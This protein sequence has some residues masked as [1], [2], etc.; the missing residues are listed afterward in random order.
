MAS[1]M[2]SDHMMLECGHG[3]DIIAS[4]C[5]EKVNVNYSCSFIRIYKYTCAR[6]CACAHSYMQVHVRDIDIIIN[7]DGC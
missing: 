6:A 2:T 3:C 5:D 7:V 4:T 1:Y